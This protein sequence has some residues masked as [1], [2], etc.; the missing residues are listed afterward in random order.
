MAA[1]T[2][3]AKQAIEEMN[4]KAVEEAHAA[5]TGKP[6]TDVVRGTMHTT[7]SR[8]QTDTFDKASTFLRSL[9]DPSEAAT[10][11][12]EDTPSALVDGA[13]MSAWKA[14]GSHRA[15][16]FF[17]NTRRTVAPTPPVK[18]AVLVDVSMSMDDIQEPASRLG[19][20]IAAAAFDMRNFAGRGAQ[21][22]VT[23][24]HWGDTVS[25]T[26]P[27]GV[28]PKGMFMPRCDQR[29]SAMADAMRAAKV[30]I[31]ALFEPSATPE[32]K[33]IVHFTDWQ[34]DRRSAVD[35]VDMN[36]EALAAGT[37]ILSIT[38][39]QLVVGSFYD[40]Y[41]DV[42][43]KYGVT[44]GGQMATAVYD[45]KNPDMVWETARRVLGQ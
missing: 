37:K 36:G 13:A 5:S 11:R 23:L 28:L 39:E 31:P 18:V 20:A 17:N 32:N 45:R 12:V 38:P 2:S 25:V 1:L 26:Q 29:T 40:S 33:L 22:E 19:W 7:R 4:Q 6:L 21:I 15:P 9:I 16:T 8:K 27:A 3:L 43:N 35:S 42:L 34:L 30:E 44:Y 24:I 41:G 10:T 14:G